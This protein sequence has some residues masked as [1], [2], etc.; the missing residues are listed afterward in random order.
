[1]SWL[2]HL[3]IEANRLSRP[4]PI[5]S[6]LESSLH[7]ECLQSWNWARPPGKLGNVPQV[8]IV[9]FA[10]LFEPQRANTLATDEVKL[11]GWSKSLADQTG[12]WSLSA[13]A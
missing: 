4:L 9:N 11:T 2:Q 10:D 12:I 1:M 7:F 8:G 5:P 3:A 13:H 6:T